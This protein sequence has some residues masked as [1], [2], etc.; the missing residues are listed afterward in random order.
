MRRE[1]GGF[2]N[3][4]R[5]GE[6]YSQTATSALSKAITVATRIKLGMASSDDATSVYVRDPLGKT[7]GR[8]DVRPDLVEVWSLGG[9]RS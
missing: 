2:T 8:V 4:S 9:G 1:A 6:T 5:D 3:T 7:V